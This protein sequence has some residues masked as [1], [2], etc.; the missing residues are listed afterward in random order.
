MSNSPLELLLAFI[1]EHPN[2]PLTINISI[3]NYSKNQIV[4]GSH[5]H[6]ILELNAEKKKWGELC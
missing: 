3:N 1:K 2:T 4:N 6:L 5:N